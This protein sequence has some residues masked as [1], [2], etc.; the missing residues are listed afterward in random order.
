MPE[1][2]AFAAVGGG[3][4]HHRVAVVAGA[5]DV[6]GV[7]SAEDGMNL[8]GLVG[9]RGSRDRQSDWVCAGAAR[10]D[11]AE[12]WYL[13]LVPLELSSQPT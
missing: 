11:L 9:P 1:F 8:V 2:E 4:D 3:P 7:T 12:F 10:R 5:D 13:V 6:D